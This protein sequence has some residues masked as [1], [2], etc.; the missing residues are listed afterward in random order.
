MTLLTEVDGF[1]LVSP[2]RGLFDYQCRSQLIRHQ[3]FEDS[4]RG[5]DPWWWIL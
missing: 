3:K 5:L 4:R 2:I 1:Y